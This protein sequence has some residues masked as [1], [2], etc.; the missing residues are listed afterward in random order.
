MKPPGRCTRLSAVAPRVTAVSPSFS[1]LWSSGT[2]L[3]VVVATARGRSPSRR[4]IAR[5]SQAARPCAH[6]AIS[7]PQA[8]WC[9][10][11]RR[12]SG[13]AAE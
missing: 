2:G 4:A 10:P 6:F 1:R 7:S 5:L 3:G 11:P 13:S 8:R 9:C 12:L